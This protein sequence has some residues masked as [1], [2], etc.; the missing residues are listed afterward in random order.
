MGLHE[1]L[2]GVADENDVHE[3]VKSNSADLTATLDRDL[4][5]C[6]N[7]LLFV[8][9]GNPVERYLLCHALRLSAARVSSYGG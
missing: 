1:R 4:Y 8:R 7:Y 3:V 2:A 5:H 9:R 6:C